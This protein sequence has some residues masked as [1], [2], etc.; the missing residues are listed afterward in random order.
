MR[1]R[2]S[3]RP[4]PFVASAS[5]LPNASDLSLER[6]AA[7]NEF[8]QNELRLEFSRTLQA[9]ILRD[10]EMARSFGARCSG[11]AWRKST[12]ATLLRQTEAGLELPRFPLTPDG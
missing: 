8:D 9:E 12:G 5:R 11:F 6:I 10:F 3:S 4:A 7:L 2:S 1:A